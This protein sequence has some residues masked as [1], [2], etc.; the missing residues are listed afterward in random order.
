[1]AS[2][3]FRHSKLEEN[4]Q[5]D[6]TQ[7]LH[8]LTPESTVFFVRH[9]W[10]F[11][12]H[13]N[14]TEW[15]KKWRLDF[16]EYPGCRREIKYINLIRHPVDRWISMWN[17]QKYGDHSMLLNNTKT[18][19]K[20]DDN[21]DIDTCIQNRTLECQDKIWKT[22][23]TG[24][25]RAQLLI[26]N[27]CG[28]EEFCRSGFDEDNK[29]ALK[30]AKK[31]IDNDYSVVGITEHYKLSIKLFAKIYPEVFQGVYKEIYKTQIDPEYDTRKLSKTLTLSSVY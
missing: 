24:K 19:Y 9:F 22:L 2:R 20:N 29:K 10:F 11:D 4:E 1:M 21:I 18:K 17:F 3:Q 30:Q 13:K 5:F 14:R 31:Q 7:F 6:L 12:M 16:L 23:K 27:I 8:C 26:V 15:T 25:R 28:Q